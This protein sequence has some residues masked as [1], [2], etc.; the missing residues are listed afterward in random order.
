MNGKSKYQVSKD[1]N[2]SYLTVIKH[3]E[4]LTN[5]PKGRPGLR[6]ETLEMLKKLTQ[7]GYVI[8]S[9]GYFHNYLTLRKH[10]PMICRVN[11][12]GKTIIFLEDKSDIATRAYLESLN[13]K[14]TNYHE[15]KRIIDIFK[16]NM[17]SEE[18][19]RYVHKKKSKKQSFSKNIEATPLRE[20]D[21]MNKRIIS[22]QEL[23][24]IM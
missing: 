17:D 21:A 24:K 22:Y 1:L 20:N 6:G 13:R 18:K 19:K 9:P 23:N 8:C 3:T 2:I 12:Y 7:D 14:I 15:L 10:F 4:D 5:H 16:T 11:V